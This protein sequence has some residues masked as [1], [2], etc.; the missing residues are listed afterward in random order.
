MSTG[1]GERPPKT[2]LLAL[3]SGASSLQD[4]ERINFRCVSPSVC[5][6]FV[7]AAELTAT[8]AVEWATPATPSSLVAG[9]PPSFPAKSHRVSP[10]GNG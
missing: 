4:C 2:N 1:Q 7:T 5:A 10:R 6:S 8:G 9:H 3:G